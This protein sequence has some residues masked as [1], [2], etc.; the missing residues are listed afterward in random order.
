MRFCSD[1]ACQNEDWMVI[2]GQVVLFSLIDLTGS[3]EFQ[4]KQI[5]LNIQSLTDKIQF[6]WFKII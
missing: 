2:Y 6:E 4:A 3:L 5:N 1:P